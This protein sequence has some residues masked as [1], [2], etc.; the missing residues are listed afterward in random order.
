MSSV[1]QVGSPQIV[2]LRP[3]RLRTPRRGPDWALGA[4][5]TSRDGMAVL[6]R[7]RGR[8]DHPVRDSRRVCNRAGHAASSLS[9]G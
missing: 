9:G 2:T 3:G 8:P 1:F 4:S 5:N 7:K 6:P